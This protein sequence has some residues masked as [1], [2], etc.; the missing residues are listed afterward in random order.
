MP[1]MIAEERREGER[2]QRKEEEE[3]EPGCDV[4]LVK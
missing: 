4:M 1:E 2:D 3:E